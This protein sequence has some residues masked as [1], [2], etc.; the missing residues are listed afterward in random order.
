MIATRIEKSGVH[1]AFCGGT[2]LLVFI[3][4][5]THLLFRNVWMTYYPPYEWPKG[6]LQ[7]KDDFFFHLFVSIP[8]IDYV[9]G[10][11]ICEALVK[12]NRKI[13][14]NNFKLTV[15]ISKKYNGK[16]DESWDKGFV[17]RKLGKYAGHIKRI[18]V[19]GPPPMNE[20]LD[21]AFEDLGHKF[22]VEHTQ[23]EVM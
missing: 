1:V 4:L 9:C 5:V 17:E 20:S 19:S 16:R 7:L 22:G 23:I 11:G 15:R 10:L 3:D 6:A 12:V 18:W 14:K 13:G 2:G 8:E 21:Q